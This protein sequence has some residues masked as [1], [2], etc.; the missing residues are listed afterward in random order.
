MLT[1]QVAVWK[2]EIFSDLQTLLRKYS[3]IAVA[4]L[5]KVR[6]SQIQEIRKKLRG[7]AE[8]IVA[9]NTIL[10]SDESI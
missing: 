1:R 5:Q 9:K 6:S 2:K 10:H 8:L 4:D 7:K 3:V